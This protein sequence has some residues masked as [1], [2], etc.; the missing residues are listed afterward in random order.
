[1]M[2][3]AIATRADP[4]AHPTPASWPAW[5]LTNTFVEG[6]GLVERLV[7]TFERSLPPVRPPARVALQAAA[8]RARDEW[9]AGSAAWKEH[10]R[11]RA[12]LEAARRELAEANEAVTKAE[13]DLKAA[14]A[15]GSPTAALEEEM[16]G[17]GPRAAVLATKAKHLAELA[18]GAR[19]TCAGEWK[20]ALLA[21]RSRVR[22]KSD[23]E[24]QVTCARVAAAVRDE[25]YEL[26]RVHDTRLALH[27]DPGMFN[28]V[29]EP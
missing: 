21:L 7:L 23:E 16:A 14:L 26:C 9:R 4:P 12:Q 11:L 15:A 2:T 19:G 18:M 22:Q 25:L 17:F 27:L 5:K 29:E 3:T 28:H 10:E 24:F 13:G 6:A 20:L 1:M 8:A